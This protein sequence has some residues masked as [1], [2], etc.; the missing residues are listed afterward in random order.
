[1]SMP[2]NIVLSNIAF[3][4]SFTRIVIDIG[5]MGYRSYLLYNMIILLNAISNKNSLY[6]PYEI[7]KV[8]VLHPRA[9]DIRL[10]ANYGRT[11]TLPPNRKGAPANL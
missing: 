1:M 8:Y 7:I 3:N 9:S 6:I 11:A 4:R 2:A 5:N 10:V